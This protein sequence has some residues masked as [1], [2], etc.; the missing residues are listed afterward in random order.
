MRVRDLLTQ[1][2]RPVVTI[3]GEK[4]ILDAMKLLTDQKIGALIVVDDSGD[5]IGILTE[6][7][8]FRLAYKHKGQFMDMKVRDQMT[9]ELIIGLPDDDVDYIAEVITQRRVRHIPIMDRDKKLC[10]IVSIGDIVKAQLTMAE[11]H[12]RY[13][14]EYITGRA[15]TDAEK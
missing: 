5:T 7:D 4:S 1:R 9:R 11:V 10:G 6:R 12:V 8:I 14:T 3:T 2:Q 13:L 15:R